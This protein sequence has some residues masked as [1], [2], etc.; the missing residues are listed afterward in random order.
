[1]LSFS[2]AV[3]RVRHA[4][5]KYERVLA[6]EA[7]LASEP[8]RRLSICRNDGGGGNRTRARFSWRLARTRSYSRT[9]TQTRPSWTTTPSGR[10]PISIVSVTVLVSGSIRETVRLTVFATHTA[11]AP[12]AIAEGWWKHVIATAG[13]PYINMHAA[14]HRAIT[15]FLRKTGNLKLA[16]LSARHADISTTANVYGHLDVGDLEAA[17]E[18]IHDS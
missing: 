6:G 9:V 15:D 12:I 10:W 1:V 4:E 14:R 7:R 18:R 8:R 11:P 5:M 3:G 17:L 16:Q 13:I 2:R